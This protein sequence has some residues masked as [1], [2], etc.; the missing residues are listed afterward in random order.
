MW[1][2]S[3][4]HLNRFSSAILTICPDAYEPIRAVWTGMEA[5]RHY[6]HLANLKFIEPLAIR[7]LCL[8]RFQVVRQTLFVGRELDKANPA[9]LKEERRFRLAKCEVEF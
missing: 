8:K 2:Y 9:L 6:P 4:L 3:Q 1:G 5:L 7:Q